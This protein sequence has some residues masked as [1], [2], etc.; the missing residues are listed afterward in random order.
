M[1]LIEATDRLFQESQNLLGK[2]EKEFYEFINPLSDYLKLDNEF[3]LKITNLIIYSSYL[4]IIHEKKITSNVLIEFIK[5]NGFLCEIVK[6]GKAKSL[7]YQQPI[8]CLLYYL[9]SIEKELTRELWPLTPDE[10]APLYTDLGK[11]FD[12]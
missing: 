3:F 11:S 2:E 7:L 10:L 6:T 8:I 1:A 5:T 12:Y 4:D 9:I